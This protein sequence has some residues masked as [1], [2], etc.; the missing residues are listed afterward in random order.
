MLRKP[1]YD[2]FLMTVSYVHLMMMGCMMFGWSGS[3]AS[4]L[5]VGLLLSQLGVLGPYLLPLA[6]HNSDS[7]IRRTVAFLFFLSL[8]SVASTHPTHH[9]KNTPSDLSWLIHGC[10]SNDICVSFPT[11]LDLPTFLP[12]QT[13]VTPHFILSSTYPVTYF[14]SIPFPCLD[15]LL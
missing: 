7:Q 10:S 5:I 3:L 11:C 12:T 1:T 6:P 14:H 2:F 8:L 13:H 4:F 9:R 15:P